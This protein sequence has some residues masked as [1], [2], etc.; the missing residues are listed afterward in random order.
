MKIPLVLMASLLAA[1]VYA[2]TAKPADKTKKTVK[3]VKKV[4]VTETPE[5]PKPGKPAVIVKKDSVVP[6]GH[7]CPACGMG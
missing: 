1:G 2:Q 7:G 5:K 3:K 4:A 6:R